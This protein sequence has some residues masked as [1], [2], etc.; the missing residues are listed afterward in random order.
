MY[1]LLKTTI[2]LLTLSSLMIAQPLWASANSGLVLVGKGQMS[3]M[4]FDLYQAHFYSQDGRYQ[5]NRYPQAL[6]LRYQKNISKDDL[7]E[8]TIREWQRLGIEYPSSWQQQLSR[9]W[10]SVKKGDELAIRVEP[11]G[12]SRFYFNQI[13]LGEMTAPKFGPAFLAI[14]LSTNS[15][16]STLTRQLKGN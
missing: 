5:A 16:D 12:E 10:P 13:P 11:T 4:F 3:W 2:M 15:Q 9:L 1:K 14:W 6:T 8:A 7:I